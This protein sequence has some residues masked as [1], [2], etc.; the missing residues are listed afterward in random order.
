[1]FKK[2]AALAVIT[3][4]AVFAA[5]APAFAAPKLTGTL[6]PAAA[7]N[8]TV[9]LSFGLTG[10][11]W[12]QALV[13]I[14]VAEGGLTIDLTGDTAAASG[15]DL[16]D[17]TAST[18]SFYGDI[19][20]VAATLED[21]IDWH[22]PPTAGEYEIDFTLEVQEYVSGL[23]YNPTNGHYYLVPTDEFGDPYEMTA[24]TAFLNA[25]NDDYT[26]AGLSGF[27][28]EINDEQENDFIAEF[29]GGEDIWIGGTAE[30]TLIDLYTEAG[31]T[32]DADW[33]WLYSWERFAQGTDPAVAL[34]GA[35]TSFAEGE[36]NGGN[37]Q[38]GCLVTNYQGDLGLWNDLACD[39]A[40]N[41]VIIEFEPDEDVESMVLTLTDETI[42]VLAETGVETDGIILTAG[43]LALAGAGAVIYRRRRA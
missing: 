17:A 31:H 3:A 7:E 42:V 24:E 14:E 13:T 41:P 15:Y 25:F 5:A 10:T 2:I 20:D 40:E 12:D 21:G 8:E 19:D 43:A 4:T 36:P 6:P 1:M 27:V 34:G 22:T 33:T 28:A 38:E 29:S 23:S 18:Q 11:E 9:P 37:N 39:S 35:F 32:T 30:H 26:Y 16:T